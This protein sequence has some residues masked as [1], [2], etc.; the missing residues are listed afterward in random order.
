L[1]QFRQIRGLYIAETALL[2]PNSWNASIPRIIRIDNLLNC[3]VA[4][5]QI[6]RIKNVREYDKKGVRMATC[7][8]IV[9]NKSSIMH[10]LHSIF[11]CKANEY[12]S[13]ISIRANSKDFNAKSIAS[14]LSAGATIEIIANG[15]GRTISDLNKWLKQGSRINLAV[16]KDK[17]TQLRRSYEE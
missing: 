17:S 6:C 7:Q 10:D 5:L 1:I 3:K 14:V 8:V 4:F 11:A 12:G 9:A 2:P 16:V 13:K 15:A